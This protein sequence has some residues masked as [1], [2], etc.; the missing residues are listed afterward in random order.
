[1]EYNR[2][3]VS[4]LISCAVFAL[5]VAYLPV[6]TQWPLL[7]VATVLAMVTFLILSSIFCLPL[8]K[9]QE[10]LQARYPGMDLSY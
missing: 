5:S 8:K 1:M 7:L 6:V 2:S 4:S 10:N 3:F 9:E